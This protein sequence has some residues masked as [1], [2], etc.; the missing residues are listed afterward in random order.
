M[1]AR[2]IQRPKQRRSE[3]KKFPAPIGGWVS[4]RALA[5]PS[6]E[7]G[8]LPQGALVLDNFMPGATTA[9]L[10]RGK[11]RFCT[12][13][14]PA[15]SLFSYNNGPIKRIFAASENTIYDITNAEF[16]EDTDI[17]TETD[18]LIVTET[19]DWIGWL[20]TD[21]LGVMSGFTGGDWSV[22]QFATTGGVYLVGVN[23]VN[24]GFIYDGDAFYPY[25]AGGV[26]T[27]E[28]DTE[29]SSFTVGDTVTG[30]TSSATGD[31]W[32][33]EPTGVDTGILYLTNI[34]AG[35]FQ[36]AEAL[37]D[38]GGGS[39][40]AVGANTAL[41]PGITFTGGKTT[42]DMSF[43][44]V[45]RNRLY[46]AET[47]TMNA[48]YLDVDSVG[49]AAAVFPLSGVFGLGGALLFGQRW[50]LSSGG[51]GGLSE[52]CVFISTEGEV[53]V[54]QGLGPDDT[55]TWSQQ[56]LYRIGRPLGKKAFIRGA[57][58][59]AIATTV[60]LVP[61]S[62]AIELD[63]TA[64]TVASI[65]YPI[66]DAWSDALQLRGAQDWQGI[67]WP[68]KKM[69]LFSPPTASIEPVMF[70]ANTETGTWSRFTGWEGDCF[71]VFEGR[72][73]FGESSGAIYIGN[74]TG[75]DDGD[76]YTGVCLPLYDD[77]GSPASRKIS[78]VGRYILRASAPVRG[79]VTW[80]SD[81]NE[82]MP[83]APSAEVLSGTANLWGE[84][85][86]GQSQWA[87]KLPSLLID[88]W[89]SLGGTGYTVS[90]AYQ[91]T[92]G[93]I[94]PLDVEIISSELLYETA[95]VVT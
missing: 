95:E 46:F 84:A 72:L 63:L 77:L 1:Y 83:P 38:T 51:D 24:T 54:Y 80:Q 36:A 9:K 42:A 93:A 22:V 43:V 6:G 57:G 39:A 78:K 40:N 69:A 23:G 92:S 65:S 5:V 21:G 70:I 68:D 19:G 60:G 16:A 31:I 47:G 58:D 82:T 66:A 18:D 89:R 33:I 88:D 13:D 48:W 76:P 4:N 25:V 79:N 32:R 20:S 30:G 7:T 53:A 52:Q 49:G 29:T 15:T 11:R 34:T 75:L 62:K 64:L 41:I 71:E 94:Q 86:W 26:E 56:G 3:V 37:T 10:R 59:L 90:L 91:V 17:V 44:W 50:S 28:Y 61:L 45:Y 8:N 81:Y 87:D 2:T 73:Y 27:L 35:P 12:L 74:E 14:G 85:V 55:A 67:I